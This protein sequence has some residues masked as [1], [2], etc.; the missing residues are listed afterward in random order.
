MAAQK[1]A[2]NDK[3]GW[4]NHV[5]RGQEGKGAHQYKTL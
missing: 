4:L 1:Q 2:Y 3:A 5:A